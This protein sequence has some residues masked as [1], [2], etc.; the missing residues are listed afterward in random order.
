MEKSEKAFGSRGVKSVAFD[1]E[2]FSADALAEAMTVAK[3]LISTTGFVPGTPFDMGR[4]ARAVDNEGTVKMVDAAKKAGVERF[5]LVSSI[6]TNGRAIGQ[7]NSAGFLITNAF[8]NILD[9]KLKAEKYLRSSGLDWT[10][11]RP[12]DLKD[13]ASVAPAVISAEDTLLSGE[14][15]RDLVAEVAVDIIGKPGASHRVVELIEQGTCVSHFQRCDGLP[16]GK[17]DSA[18]WFT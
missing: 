17:A 1:V 2:T 15:S 7:E 11:L 18:A 13:R 8:G 10:I 3:F 5:V 4:L 12:G 6:L 14:V 16:A 9:E